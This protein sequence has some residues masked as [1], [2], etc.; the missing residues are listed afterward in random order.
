MVKSEGAGRCE[1][2][3][4]C[5]FE[6]TKNTRTSARDVLLALIINLISSAIFV[7]LQSLGVL[8][9]GQILDWVVLL[10]VGVILAI[11]ASFFLARKKKLL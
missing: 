1:T 7:F 6:N 8:T 11:V 3:Q 2:I 9:L 10:F 4:A 5:E